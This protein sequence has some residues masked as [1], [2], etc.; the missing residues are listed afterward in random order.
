MAQVAPR[1]MWISEQTLDFGLPTYVGKLPYPNQVF[2]SH[3]FATLLEPPWQAPKPEYATPL[4][5][6][7]DQAKTAGGAPWVGEIGSNPGTVGTAWSGREMN[8]LEK[9][10][11][12]WAYWDWDQKGSWAFIRQPARLKLVA[13]AYPKATPGNLTK[14]SYDPATGELQ[15]DFQ[16]LTRGRPLLIAV[17]YFLTGYQVSGSD[18]AADV[19]SQLSRSHHTLSITIHDQRTSHRV[20]VS[21]S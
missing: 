15:V 2:S 5:L 3:I 11:L 16:G 6:L 14:L 18:P 10:L 12:G 13:R 20:K 9:Y 7:R 19:S 4:T 17:P 21:F 1:Q 8:E